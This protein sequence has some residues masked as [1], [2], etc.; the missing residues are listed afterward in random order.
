VN[1]SDNEMVALQRVKFL[2]Q[3][4]SLRIRLTAPFLAPPARA[5]AAWGDSAPSSAAAVRHESRVR[6]CEGSV[7]HEKVQV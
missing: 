2:K 6:R 5:P 7:P 1:K 3:R 4:F